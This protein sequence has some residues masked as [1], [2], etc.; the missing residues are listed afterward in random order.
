MS[1]APYPQMVHGL[2]MQANE[3]SVI[4]EPTLS[5]PLSSSILS[6]L[7]TPP[8]FYQEFIRQTPITDA[9][10]LSKQILA[11]GAATRSIQNEPK[12]IEIV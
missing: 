6:D 3:M 8:H 7:N 9:Y 2:Q 12:P 5:N 11:D 10:A 1:S 4:H